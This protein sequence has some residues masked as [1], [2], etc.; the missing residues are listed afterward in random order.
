MRWCLSFEDVEF[1][2]EASGLLYLLESVLP[3]P[4]TLSAIS[5]SGPSVLL[6]NCMFTPSTISL[7]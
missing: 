6:I 7:C 2:F 5:L 1:F 4:T 3:V